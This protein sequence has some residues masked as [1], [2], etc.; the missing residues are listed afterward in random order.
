VVR[1]VDA[2]AAR[3]FAHEAAPWFREVIVVPCSGRSLPMILG[4]IALAMRLTLRGTVDDAC[5]QVGAAVAGTRILL[6]LEGMDSDAPFV[7]DGE[8]SVLYAPAGE[9]GPAP[10]D[11][12][13]L[14][15]FVHWPSRGDE[16]VLY[17]PHIEQAILASEWSVASRLGKA[18]FAFLKNHDRVFEAAHVARLLERR[19]ST[20]GEESVTAW[21]AEELSW[22]T[23]G[24]RVFLPRASGEQ[25]TLFA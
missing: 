4:E 8:A 17:V 16:C 24:E 3:Q 22:I 2:L 23:G 6:V 25:M 19:A 7:W 10:S 13:M 1:V 11:G 20:E 18:A 21:A 12:Q 9:P 14:G 5:E 15:A